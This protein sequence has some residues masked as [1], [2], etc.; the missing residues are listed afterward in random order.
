M[1]RYRP[2]K[3]RAVSSATRDERVRSVT[4]LWTLLTHERGGPDCHSIDAVV[5]KRSSSSSV[6]EV[7]VATLEY[8]LL[9]SPESYL[10]TTRCSYAF[11]GDYFGVLQSQILPVPWIVAISELFRCFS[12]SN[13][14]YSLSWCP[15]TSNDHIL[16]SFC[17]ISFRCSFK[18][19]QFH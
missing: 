10:A 11:T 7:Q 4:E 5:L 16:R 18:D 6:P 3:S 9:L 2:A 15:P 8:R 12:V 14:P 1:I 19:T 13:T 17:V